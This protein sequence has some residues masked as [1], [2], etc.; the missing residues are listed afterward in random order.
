MCN[1]YLRELAELDDETLTLGI[2]SR[3][4]AHPSD[5]Y[6]ILLLDIMPGAISDFSTRRVYEALLALP[7]SHTTPIFDATD[8]LNISIADTDAL[9]VVR[10][11][12][13]CGHP[14]GL[15]DFVQ[16]LLEFRSR[17]ILRQLDELAEE[18][19]QAWLE[20][21]ELDQQ[22]DADDMPW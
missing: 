15:V 16:C 6:Y 19:N 21:T 7:L 5:R 18:A 9:D 11:A 22:A 2:I 12:R 3:I 14:Y 17:S 10:K 4:L 8:C 20:A 13:E 1:L